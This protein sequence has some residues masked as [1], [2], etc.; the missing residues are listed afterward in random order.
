MLISLI[1]LFLSYLLGAFSDINT[2]K[3]ITSQ[4]DLYLVS[5]TNYFFQ[6]TYFDVYI[7]LFRK[8]KL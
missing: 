6:C 3:E 7:L 1:V 4:I 2:Q 8:S 5:V